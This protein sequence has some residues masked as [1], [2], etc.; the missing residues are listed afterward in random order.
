MRLTSEVYPTPPARPDLAA[1]QWTLAGRRFSLTSS[2]TRHFPFGISMALRF[3]HPDGP[4]C[5]PGFTLDI[6]SHLGTRGRLSAWTGHRSVI[7]ISPR[8][9]RVTWYRRPAGAR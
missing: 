4:L 1:R 5:G 9:P 8:R 7:T 6:R 2:F 3:R